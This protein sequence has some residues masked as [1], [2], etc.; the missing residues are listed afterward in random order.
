MDFFSFPLE[1]EVGL[2]LSLIAIKVTLNVFY[3]GGEFQSRLFQK[4]NELNRFQYSVKT[5]TEYG[6]LLWHRR[7]RLTASNVII[8]TAP[9]LFPFPVAHSFTHFL[10]IFVL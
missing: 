3:L 6:V 4:D 2:S 7:A 8:L 5:K 1:T 9:F 10:P